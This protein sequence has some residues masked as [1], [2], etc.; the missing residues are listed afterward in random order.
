[1]KLH[2]VCDRK[3]HKMAPR[4]DVVAPQWMNGAVHAKVP[5][6]PRD[7]YEQR[8]VQDV[9]IRC[10]FV[11]RRITPAGRAAMGDEDE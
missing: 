3:G 8:Y 10:G 2:E 1:M 6:H 4:Y 5:G 9:C 11:A 7:C